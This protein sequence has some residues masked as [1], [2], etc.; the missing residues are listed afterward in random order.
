MSAQRTPSIEIYTMPGCRY[1]ARARALLARHGLKYTETD[2][3]DIPGVRA[4]L[5]ERFGR[6]TVPQIV[7]DGEPIGGSDDLARLARLRV[8]DALASG[9]T[10]PIM[11]QERVWSPKTLMRWVLARMRG[12]RDARAVYHVQVWLDQAGRVVRADRQ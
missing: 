7:I 10:F 11:Y 9:R 6:G 12:D 2:V 8:L 4:W 1:C 5:V 3:H